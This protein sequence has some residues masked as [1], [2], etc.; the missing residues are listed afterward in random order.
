MEDRRSQ[1]VPRE[2]EEDRSHLG[3]GECPWFQMGQGEK[4]QCLGTKLIM[5]GYQGGGSESVAMVRFYFNY[6]VTAVA[7]DG[8]S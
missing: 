1:T 2:T 8:R 3:E 5:T 6:E 4:I 7:M